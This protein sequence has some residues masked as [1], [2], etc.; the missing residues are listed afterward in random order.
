M[1]VLKENIPLYTCIIITKKCVYGKG[2]RSQSSELPQMVE[3]F[4]NCIHKRSSLFTVILR[5]WPSL[6][7]TDCCISMDRRTPEFRQPNG[8][9][10]L[11]SLIHRTGGD[12]KG[13]QLI[14]GQIFPS[15]DGKDRGR[16]YL[17]YQSELKRELLLQ[18]SSGIR[19]VSRV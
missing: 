16:N 17:K 8:H 5:E 14:I 18:T 6:K 1:Y 9:V 3:P 7:T 12:E 15:D 10:Y 19:I 2:E 13:V 4:I 11:Y